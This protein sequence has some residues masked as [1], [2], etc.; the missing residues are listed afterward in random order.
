MQVILDS[1]V[2]PVFF[3]PCRYIT[4]SVQN[5]L[6]LRIHGPKEHRCRIA[7][8]PVLLHATC[9]ACS[10]ANAA[11]P[12]WCHGAWTDL[13]HGGRSVEA[14]VCNQT[15]DTAISS[16]L[17]NIATRIASRRGLISLKLTYFL[18]LLRFFFYFRF[19]VCL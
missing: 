15:R 19:Y 12:L 4:I 11:L 3:F 7:A 2:L 9:T 13:L 16:M 10:V 1:S 5:L 8:T 17:S 6:L 14:E 18:F